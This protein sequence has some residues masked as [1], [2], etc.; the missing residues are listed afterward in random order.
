MVQRGLHSLWILSLLFHPSI[1]KQYP[2]LKFS[3]LPFKLLLVLFPS[4]D[5][6]VHYNLHLVHYNLH[7]L[8][9]CLW[10]TFHHIGKFPIPIFPKTK[11]IK[12]MTCLLQSLVRIQFG[13]QLPI[14]RHLVSKTRLL[15]ILEHKASICPSISIAFLLLFCC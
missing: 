1:F 3:T 2:L 13:S 7:F 11:K 10:K 8:M 14:C 6:L 15:R 9:G 12:T 5:V 4:L